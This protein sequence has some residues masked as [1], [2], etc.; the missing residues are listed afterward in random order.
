M[1]ITVCLE[2]PYLPTTAQTNASIIEK[3][4]VVLPC[5]AR[6]TPLPKIRWFKNGVPLSGTEIGER[7][8]PDGSLQLEHAHSNNT[9]LYTCVAEN[10][11]G[12]VT[13]TIELIVYGQ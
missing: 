3:N 13:L 12:N 4:R 8:M 9:G 5:P 11:A 2:P 6:G 1:N 7:L 10:I